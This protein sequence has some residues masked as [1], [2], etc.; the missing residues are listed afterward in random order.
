MKTEDDYIAGQSESEE[1]DELRE[2]EEIEKVIETKAAE[3]RDKKGQGPDRRQNK[4]TDR[5]SGL[6]R[7]RGGNA[8]DYDGPE[9]RKNKDRRENSE[10]DRRRGPGRRRSDERRSAEEGEMNDEQFAFVMAI[11]EYK[12]ANKRPFPTYTE[13]LEIAKALGYRKVEPAQPITAGNSKQRTDKASETEKNE[14]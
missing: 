7:R 4:D 3:R 11:D 10:W 9:R 6:D 12:R 13:I 1:M 5:R 14:E 2:L 8:K